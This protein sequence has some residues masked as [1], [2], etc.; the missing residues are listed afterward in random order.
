MSSC[1]LLITSS[2]LNI[3][4]VFLPIPLEISTLHLGST[5]TKRTKD[6]DLIRSEC[7]VYF[8]EFFIE[9]FYN[10]VVC[11][12]D[13]KSQEKK[14]ERTM[15]CPDPLIPPSLAL[16]PF[17]ATLSIPTRYTSRNVTLFGCAISVSTQKF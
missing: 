10:V 11:L 4:P 9:V 6:S 12:H 13:L 14:R 3:W 5:R 1:F 17:G 15:R 7:S 16:I 2:S 8:L